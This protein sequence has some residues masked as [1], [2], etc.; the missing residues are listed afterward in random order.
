MHLNRYPYL[1]TF[2][3]ILLL[4]AITGCQPM[5]LLQTE[6][7]KIDGN[8]TKM[9]EV[10]NIRGVINV[11]QILN[12]TG[13]PELQIREPSMLSG[14]ATAQVVYD[15]EAGVV[16][17]EARYEGL[18]YRPTL[19]YDYDP[20]N[21]YNEWPFPCVENGEWQIWFA[22]EVLVGTSAWYYDRDTKKLLGHHTELPELVE[23]DVIAVEYPVV[24]MVESPGF[25]P[26]PE[27]LIAEVRFEYNYHQILDQNGS[28]GTMAT[29][30][31]ANLCNPDSLMPYWVNGGLPAEMASDFD[32]VLSNIEQGG[33]IMLAISYG[34]NPKPDYLLARDNIMIG[35]LGA[36]PAEENFLP[37]STAT[38]TYHQTDAGSAVAMPELSFDGIECD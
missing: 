34:P 32:E 23:S 35:W 12:D 6:E 26:D 33:M 8:A 16:A 37:V 24:Q 5:I 2:I 27:T 15:R 20:S 19:C 28:A 36:G 25:E 10:R 3:S 9:E 38:E 7:D 21:D 29:G 13:A 17:V 31:R 1:T 18:P 11:P 14:S 4:F 30:V 22:T